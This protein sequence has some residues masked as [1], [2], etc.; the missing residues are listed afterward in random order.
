MCVRV[1][2]C[3]SVSMRTALGKVGLHMSVG[4]Q[5]HRAFQAPLV[6]ADDIYSALGIQHDES[7]VENK[8]LPLSLSFISHAII[9]LF[10]IEVCR[11]S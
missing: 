8:L 7:K 5:K 11:V 9:L 2:V 3:V 6:T 10:L 1:C 4:L